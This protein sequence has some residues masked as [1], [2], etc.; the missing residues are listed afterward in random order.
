MYGRASH[1]HI[2]CFKNARITLSM[3]KIKNQ[4]SSHSFL[5]SS[6]RIFASHQRL[7]LNVLRSTAIQKMSIENEYLCTI[8]IVIPYI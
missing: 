1:D 4:M 2:Y 5:S 7:D 8:I 6:N 3:L